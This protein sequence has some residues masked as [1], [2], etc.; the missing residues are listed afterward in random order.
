MAEAGRPN[1]NFMNGVPELLILR[2]LLER[3]MYGYQLVRAIRGATGEAIAL[4]EGVIYPALHALEAD[5]ALASRRETVAGRTRV[6][7]R[8]TTGGRRRLGRIT[9]D[10]SRIT[11]AIRDVLRGPPSEKPAF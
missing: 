2:L 3:E 5:G 1:P 10:Y 8:V 7:Y 11:G 9:K 4:G 6:Y